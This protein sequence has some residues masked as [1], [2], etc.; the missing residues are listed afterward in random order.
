MRLLFATAILMFAVLGPVRADTPIFHARDGAAIGG[1]DTVA[2]FTTGAAVPGTP[3]IVVMWKGVVWQFA[4]QSHRD[5]F[6]ANPR[7][8]APQ[9][10]GYCAFAVS[11]GY[12]VGT[13]P[14]IWRIID[15]KLY[16]IHNASVLSRWLTDLDGNLVM[17]ETN[18]PSVLFD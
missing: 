17:S 14:E 7:A 5:A 13:D 15:G 9:Y 16:L 3:E 1:Y 2:Y 12:T 10:G 8:Y 4:S 11:Q 18:W 6:E